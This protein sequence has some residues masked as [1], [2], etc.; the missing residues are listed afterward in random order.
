MGKY[1]APEDVEGVARSVQQIDKEIDKLVDKGVPL[2]RIGVAGMSMGGCLAMHVAL[3][4]GR[5]A[6]RL[7]A[8]ASLSSFLPEDSSLDALATARHKDSEG[9]GVPLFMAHGGSDP[10]IPPVWAEATR[11]RLEC[12]RVQV[13]PEVT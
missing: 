6:G 2:N 4:S 11:R 8:V 13:P 10:M 12:A 3:G 5:Y 1:E 7:G 9:G